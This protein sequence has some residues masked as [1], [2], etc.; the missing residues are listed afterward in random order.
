[1]GEE[2]R[3]SAL[4]E[5]I[6]VFAPPRGDVNLSDPQAIAC[7]IAADRWSAV[8]NAAAYTEVDQAESEEDS[9]FAINAKAPAELSAQTARYAIP[10]I[11]IST[12]Y[13]FDG[14]KGAP[15]VEQDETAPVN[16]Y[17]RSKLAVN[18][19]SGPP[20]LDTSS[21]ARLGSIARTARIL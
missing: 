9:A 7:V 2:L 12:D 16:A 10:L 4:L 6:E 17:G 20:I 8:I 18:G 3:A 13:V 11:H 5:G 19:A 15:Y 21:C 14:R 1:V